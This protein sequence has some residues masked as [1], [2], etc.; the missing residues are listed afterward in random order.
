[1][2]AEKVSG[3]ATDA[4]PPYRLIDV[5]GPAY[6]RGRQHGR[7][8][9]DLIRRYPDVLRRILGTEGRL[10][11]PNSGPRELIDRE[12]E[13]RAL[14]FLPLF[15]EFAPEQ[16]AEIRGIADGAEIPFGMALLVNVRA[17]I[18]V[19][20]KLAREAA[21]CT[22]FAA[23]P[24]STADGGVLIGQN[25]DQSRLMGELVVILRVEPERGPRI[26]TATFAGLIGY[27]GINSAG[28]GLM[29][30]SLANSVWRFGLPHYPLKR[31]FLE[32]QDVAGCLRLLDR[33]RLGS[34]ANY[35][36]CDREQVVDVETTPDGY[37]ILPGRDGWVSHT[38]NFLD[39][40]LAAD[41]RLL[42]ALPDS[43]PRC[44]RMDRLVAERRGRIRL[45]DA[46][47][48][49]SDHDGHPVSICR[50]PTSDSPTAMTSIYSVIC[51]ADKGLL[52]VT[53]GN[54][55]Q[56]PYHTYSLN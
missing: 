55:C 33:A 42:A 17:E 13:E 54:P 20:D 56:N 38:N 48:W 7:A 28:V 10:R 36:L 27:G 47:G 6:E 19:F 15:E 35:V 3:G 51:E 21:G 23:G 37:A 2:Q 52:H 1:M 34:C 22:A 41:E 46:K 4:A 26:L 50:H 24:A 31:A 44:A 49:L 9:G 40:T 12:L 43:A 25:Q 5:A 53:V 32:Q 30:N 11:D 14:R 16:V 8:A 45:D 18:G 29:Q 39:P